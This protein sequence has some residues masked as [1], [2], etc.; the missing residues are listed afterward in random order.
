[1]SPTNWL[2]ERDYA[3]ERTL[4]LLESVVLGTNGT[5]YRHL[6]IRSKIIRADNPLFV[7]VERNDR[8]LGNVTFCKRKFGWYVR[9]FAFDPNYQGKGKR[10][11]KARGN[12][13]VADQ[14]EQFF[15]KSQSEAGLFYAYIDPKNDKSLWMSERFGFQSIGK[16]ATQTFSSYRPKL[17]VRHRLANWQEVEK[18]VLQSQGKL[19]FF[20]SCFLKSARFHVLEE[21]NQIIGLCQAEKANW[22]F[23]RLPGK[24][25]G[26]LVKTLPFVPVLRRFVKPKNHTFIV[27]E[28]VWIKN[29]DHVLLEELF[30]SVLFSLN[31]NMI[32]WWVDEKNETY[33][34][35]RNKTNWGLMHRIMGVH[36][37]DLVC[38]AENPSLIPDGPF[39]TIA[40]DFI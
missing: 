30:N 10:K 33:R 23:Q 18:I 14:V 28:A 8:L 24:L 3:D 22:E 19:A 38:R 17:S 7:A 37:V 13:V 5:Q 2:K 11:P 20:D 9:Y 29:N 12:S 6:D 39:Y 32:L 36:Q 27:P 21:N 15:L 26:I 16:M 35:V 31:Q 1:M 40:F 34:A 4:S 25:G